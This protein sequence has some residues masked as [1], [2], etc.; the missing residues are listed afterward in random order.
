MHAKQREEEAKPNRLSN[1]L[2]PYQ[3]LSYARQD[4]DSLFFQDRDCNPSML[5]KVQEA[6]LC[7]GSH[8]KPSVSPA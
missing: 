3:F 8:G 4:R 7:D 2:L 5:R 6:S 1:N